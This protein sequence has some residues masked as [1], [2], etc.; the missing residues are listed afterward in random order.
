MACVTKYHCDGYMVRIL[1]SKV[2]RINKKAG[3]KEGR[4]VGRE[5]RRG[6]KRREGRGEETKAG[7]EEGQQEEGQE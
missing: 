3:N 7:A 4:N 2:W 5:W 1:K 6:R